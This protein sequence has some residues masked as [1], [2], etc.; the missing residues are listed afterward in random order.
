MKR[1]FLFVIAFAFILSACATTLKEPSPTQANPTKTEIKPTLAPTPT[2]VAENIS[3]AISV[4]KI[5]PFTVEIKN[6]SQYTPLKIYR[7]FIVYTDEIAEI[8]PQST[9]IDKVEWDGS[10]YTYYGQDSLNNKTNEIT[11]E[12]DLSEKTKERGPIYTWDQWSEWKGISKYDF[13]IVKGSK[14]FSQ[15]VHGVLITV[16][17]EPGL[18][19]LFP[20]SQMELIFY[21]ALIAFHRLWILFGG[22]PIDEYKFIIIDH[23]LTVEASM[24]G[25]KAT[26]QTMLWASGSYLRFCS[27]D[28]SHEMT[29][30]WW[31]LGPLTVNNM[32]PPA[33]FE[34][35]TV[36]TN[37]LV[38]D[39]GIKWIQ[40]IVDEMN[41]QRFKTVPLIKFITNGDN[42]NYNNRMAGVVK[43]QLFFYRIAEELNKRTGKTID[44]FFKYLYQEHFLKYNV[45]GQKHYIA[46]PQMTTSQLLKDLN[47][48][49]GVDFTDLFDKYMY[50]KEDIT[51]NLVID[52]KYLPSFPRVTIYDN[53]NPPLTIP[54]TIDGDDSDWVNIKKTNSLQFPRLDPSATIPVKY[55]DRSI[56]YEST[57]DKNYLVIKI[58]TNSPLILNGPDQ[59]LGCGYDYNGINE[60]PDFSG[61]IG[62][63][64]IYFE[65]V[66]NVIT[67]NI[68][69]NASIYL[70][71]LVYKWKGD[72]LE[73]AVPKAPLIKAGIDP[74]K[75]TVVTCGTED[76]F[77]YLP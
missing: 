22:F 60:P 70:P 50:G 69:K 49:A 9:F 40:A 66:G 7:K 68:R 26:K 43:G 31:G 15:R 11:V 38:L 33:F 23:S 39:D 63:M 12:M 17:F 36:F 73:A 47:D 51:E 72:I 27:Q 8:K 77:T 6:N 55:P 48:F 10:V 56:L 74:E 19:E 4:T 61:N 64:Y 75:M 58:K 67:W 46:S 20:N 16:S 29:H 21:N 59:T 24:L 18:I 45:P 76:P 41:F 13:N 1:I 62:D 53:P 14:V 28:V 52:P 3:Q 42:S 2:L 30:A 32:I 65:S 44:Q 25:S 71:G 5:D 57:E 34:G 37:E 35:A 54:I